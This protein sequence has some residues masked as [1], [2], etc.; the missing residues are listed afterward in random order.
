[1]KKLYIC[2]LILLVT[3]AWPKHGQKVYAFE[4]N[5]LEYF[6]LGLKTSMAYKKTTYFTKAIELNPR[7][8][9]A[10]EKRGLNYYFQEKYQEVIED[11]TDYTRLVPNKADAYQ[12][13]GMA[14]LKIKNYEKAIVNFDRAIDLE[15]EIKGV[16]GYRAEAF[17]MI[18]QLD[19]AIND[20]N[21]AL[22]MEGD[23]R[24]LSDIYRTR[25]KVYL[26]LDQE[27]LA[28]ADLKRA[29]EIDPRYF[30]YRYISGYAD[31]EDMRRAGL[32]GM[33]GMAFV[34]IF[35]L[36]LKPPKKDE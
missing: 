7:L 16:F 10:Y 33:I 11:F 26:E 9:T 20:S 36:R 25:A 12:I 14:H 23:L 13:L 6:D 22:A 35:G 18:G 28:N 31:P 24:I 17:R 27:V 15:P 8:A 1:M 30:F 5:A 21:R 3:I 4:K 2:I 34:F 32:I 29:A 19:E